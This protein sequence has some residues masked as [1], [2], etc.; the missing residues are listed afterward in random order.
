MNN[1]EELSI[2]I[3]S[4]N[5]YGSGII[6]QVDEK[7]GY[8]ITAK[9][10]IYD[11]ETNDF[12]S[13]LK[14]LDYNKNILKEIDRPLISEKFDLA[15]IKVELQNSYPPL[16]I[17]EP[18]N[19]NKIVLFGY[20][21]YMRSKE[22]GIPIRGS[23]TQIKEKSVIK[24]VMDNGLDS[25]DGDEHDNTRGFS[26]SGVYVETSDTCYLVGMV[27]CL[28]GEGRHGI[29]NG[30]HINEI[31]SYFKSQCNIEIVP[32]NLLDFSEYLE[33]ILSKIKLIEGGKS[34]ISYLISDCYDNEFEGLT[35]AKIYEQLQDNLIYP[36]QV[37]FD[38]TNKKLW[39]GWLEVLLCKL[40]QEDYS[41]DV[42]DFY[43][44]VNQDKVRSGIHIIFTNQILMEHFIGEIFR[45]NLH[46]KIDSKD[47]V[48]I[49]STD[50][51]YDDLIAKKNQLKGIV[52]NIDDPQ[53][54]RNF[55]V[56]DPNEYK[57]FPIIHINYLEKEVTKFILINKNKSIREMIEAF[58][59][60]LNDIFNEIEN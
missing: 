27:T 38:Y 40:L 48:F 12:F 16:H 10:C 15:I 59:K 28:D 2:N 6:Y 8:I 37:F 39:T 7:I 57:I 43:K 36:N 32:K 41:F 42:A 21:V 34:S 58:P 47:V 20:P 35:P 14:Y 29:I 17:G 45:N 24:V 31:K 55:N 53:V 30:I 9:H 60:K 54:D 19:N 25:F 13:D 4:S 33:N 50:A 26:G 44:A 3:T 49:N 51:F 22:E 23:V 46:E 1:F 5:T 18:E 52:T 56:D 11:A